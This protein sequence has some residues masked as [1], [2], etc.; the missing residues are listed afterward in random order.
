MLFGMRVSNRAVFPQDAECP[1]SAGDS[2]S[3]GCLVGVWQKYASVQ[4]SFVSLCLN[5]S[6][7][8]QTVQFHSF[9]FSVPTSL[10]HFQRVQRWFH[11]ISGC[12]WCSS[13]DMLLPFRPP[14]QAFS[15]SPTPNHNACDKAFLVFLTQASQS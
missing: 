5:I 11:T 2:A 4:A 10:T 7:P 13:G 15:L 6:I 8:L 3:E 9:S 12:T 14:S 1:A